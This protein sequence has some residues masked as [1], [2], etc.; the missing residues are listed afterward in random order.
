LTCQSTNY[1]EAAADAAEAEAEAFFS[2]FFAEAEADAAAGAEA[3]AE[4]EA[5]AEAEADGAAIWLAANAETANKDAT[6]AAIK[7][8]ILYSSDRC[9]LERLDSNESL[10]ITW[11]ATAR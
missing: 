6:R 9:Y 2:I 7:F 8:F 3:A 10:L 11:L 4:A 5:L 1:F